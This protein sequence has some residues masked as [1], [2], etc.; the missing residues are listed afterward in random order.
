MG[1]LKE[2]SDAALIERTQELVGI[3][4]DTTTKVLEHLREIE[5]RRL[6]SSLGMSSLFQYCV[7]ILKYSES[8]ANRRISSM[9]LLKSLE[10]QTAAEIKLKVENGSL[11]LSH[12]AQA[13][14][15]F[16]KESKNNAVLNNGG[17]K[18]ILN[19]LEGKS[20]R[21]AETI[22]Q[23]A[24][25]QPIPPIR[26]YT[27]PASNDRTEIHLV[28]DKETMGLLN[29]VRGL[30][31]H[32]HPQLTWGELIGIVSKAAW[33]KLDPAREPKRKR[34]SNS[35]GD[36]DNQSKPEAQGGSVQTKDPVHL[37]VNLTKKNEVASGGTNKPK[38]RENIPAAMKREIWRR[39][40]SK[41]ST[42][43]PLTGRACGSTRFLQIH[44]IV[45]VALGGLTV[46]SNLQLRC[47]YCNQRAAI[48]D[49]GLKRMDPYLR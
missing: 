42:V 12:L 41:C 5:R 14:S 8:A 22:L 32:S 43:N 45:A 29:Q 6:F 49:L 10:P 15:F 38:P 35:T 16:T 34:K 4:R 44:H 20:T 27:R 28:V 9:R 40:R 21:Q 39:D 31:S 23:A 11:T 25:S 17:K 3:E 7:E 46:I 48:D 18:E 26:E 47:A 2:L 33:E 19:S 36:T 1:N 37:T 24:S 13:Q 30:L